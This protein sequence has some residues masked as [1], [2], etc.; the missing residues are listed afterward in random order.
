L[1]LLI[2]KTDKNNPC[3]DIAPRC[4]LGPNKTPFGAVDAKVYDT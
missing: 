1:L 2:S 3:G 4:D